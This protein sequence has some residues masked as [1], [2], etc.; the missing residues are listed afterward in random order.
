MP[1][2]QTQRET[3]SAL[4]KM[5]AVTTSEVIE[6]LR[7]IEAEQRD[8][9][10]EWSGEIIVGEP[11][12]VEFRRFDF[13]ALRVD[14]E[15]HHYADEESALADGCWRCESC[16][17][18]YY[19]DSFP[20][21]EVDGNRYCVSDC[22]REAGWETC[23]YCDEWHRADDMLIIDDCVFCNENC[24]ECEGYFRCDRCDEWSAD[25]Y[26]VY[27]D[28]GEVRY[29]DWCWDSNTSTCNNCGNTWDD[30]EMTFDEYGDPYCPDCGGSSHSPYLHSYGWTPCISF[31]GKELFL[32][33]ELETDGGSDRGS[34][35]DE[36]HDIKGFPDRFWMTEDGSLEEGVE[37]TSHPMSLA[38]HVKWR[39]IYEHISE[40]AH[41]YGFVSHD[42]GRCGLHVHVNRDFFGKSPVVQ[43]AGGYKMMRLLQ[44]FERQFT[45]FSRRQ[46]NHWCGYSTSVDFEP[47]KDDV[48]I[49][50]AEHHKEAGP[51]QKARTMKRERAH[52]QALNFEHDETFEWRIFRGT[53]KW[54]TY[55]ACLA[56]V[57]GVARTVKQ[58]GS[59]WVESVSWYDLM[60]EVV[61]NVSEQFPK[62]CLVNYLNEK[63]LR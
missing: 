57:D 33:T 52:S 61:E 36:L 25:P 59:T 10:C 47:K 62:S 20:E 31:F 41:R 37:I 38:E 24:A 40:T 60:D 22:A 63:G 39:S 6:R 48:S 45:I 35:C 8:I 21:V 54:S 26:W 3:L 53:L 42:G 15:I 11:F 19:K 9:R 28:H 2:T 49:L 4:Y 13:G 12:D 7:K 32:G 58:H 51:L 1:Y 16:G 55:F 18:M 50:K 34:Y 56:M 44:R 17:E 43:D 14:T 46:D 23:Q 27:T 30:D 5:G 29:C